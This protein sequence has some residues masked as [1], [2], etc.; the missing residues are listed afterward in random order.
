MILAEKSAFKR[1][2]EN[3]DCDFKTLINTATERG[4]KDMVKFLCKTYEAENTLGQ[5]GLTAL[6]GAIRVR[7][8]GTHLYKYVLKA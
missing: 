8:K 1:Q 7:D 4:Y 5:K 2:I 6:L 3:S